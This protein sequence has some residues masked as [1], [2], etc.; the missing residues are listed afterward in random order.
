MF[1]PFLFGAVYPGSCAGQYPDLSVVKQLD[2]AGED[3]FHLCDRDPVVCD[4]DALVLGA[5][6]TVFHLTVIEHTAAAVD[7]QTVRRQISREFGAA[8]K[9]KFWFTAGV[10]ADQARK[11]YCAD[12]FALAVVG[13]AF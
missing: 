10:A 4:R 11:L 8:C 6:E 13:A 9:V 3:A 2:T 1:L 7:D 12:I 5:G